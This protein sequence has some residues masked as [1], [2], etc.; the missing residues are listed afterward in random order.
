MTVFTECSK[1][2]N[3]ADEE[4]ISKS[5]TA[6]ANASQDIFDEFYKEDTTSEKIKGTTQTV[7]P[8]PLV[9]RK[10]KQKYTAKSADKKQSIKNGQIAIQVSSVKSH[11][12]AAKIAGKLSEKGYPA[13]I[14]SVKDPTPA[15]PGVYYRVRIG[16]FSSVEEAQ[17]FAENKLLPEGYRFWIDKK[18]NDT[19][20]LRKNG[21]F[22]SF[23]ASAPD[24]QEVPIPSDPP[25]KPMPVVKKTAPPAP[26]V[27]NT[28]KAAAEPAAEP[29]KDEVLSKTETINKSPVPVTI[30]KE[31]PVKETPTKNSQSPEIPA[32]Q[33]IIPED[34][35]PEFTASPSPDTKSD[36]NTEWGNEGW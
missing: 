14:T 32:D 8:R 22:S 18:S 17:S 1:K 31:T 23:T 2:K 10:E 16:G 25:S 11:A 13:Y 6:S 33:N 12:F 21:H 26:K 9:T 28:V 24:K 7:K 19:V 5:A 15:L 4:F 35:D 30:V 20:G 36:I 29:I 27:V 34:D 3:V